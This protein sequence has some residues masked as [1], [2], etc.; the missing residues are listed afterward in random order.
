MHEM[1][2]FWLRAAAALYAIGLFHTIQVAIRKGHSIFRAALVAF[3]VGLVL[4]LVAIVEAS[5]AAKHFPPLGF[6][7]SISLCAFLFGL[8]FLFLYR[9]YRFESLG[10]A[11]FPLVFVMT[12]VA[13]IKSPVGPWTDPAARDTSL[14]VHILLVL[15][16]YAALVLTALAS[17][18]YLIQERHLKRKKSMALLEKLPPLGT[19]DGII[20][21]SMGF[22]FV[23]MT[24]GV[25]T[26]ATFI[27]AGPKWMDPRLTTALVTWAFCLV[28]VF[29][30]VTAGWRGRKAALMAVTVVACSAATWAVHYVQP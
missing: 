12:A 16:G 6:Y 15:L 30:R 24:V 20:S 19:L 7:N 18:L 14:I 2:V 28:M 4:H 10:V 25:V 13:S 23:F 29:L 17:L 26:G 5:Q 1:S 21:K 8:L 9:K 3:C 22:G 27:E 11:L